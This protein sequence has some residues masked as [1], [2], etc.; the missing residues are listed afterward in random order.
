MAKVQINGMEFS[1]FSD[2][3]QEVRR[4]LNK[5]ISPVEGEDRAFV[6]DFLA[7]FHPSSDERIIGRDILSLTI[8]YPAGVISTFPCFHLTYEEAPDTPIDIS[9]KKCTARN[10]SANGLALSK[11][12]DIR[13]RSLAGYRTAIGAQ[14]K[15]YF[16]RR[17]ASGTLYSDLTRSRDCGRLGWHV[18]H[19]YPF[20]LLV[21]DFEA[22]LTAE[23]PRIPEVIDDLV[24]NERRF[25]SD[26]ANDRDYI[27]LWCDY[28]EANATLQILTGVENL[29]KGR[30]IAGE[31]V[32]A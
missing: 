13:R 14:T 10:A 24:I 19:V 16:D 28:H 23:S 1:R 4:I 32:S 25:S 27:R 15:A 29:Q 8:G 11:A 21:S 20:H 3:M 22:T 5:G 17:S 18:D 31:K 9:Y 2:A 7:Q 30:F 26:T 6:L 12:V